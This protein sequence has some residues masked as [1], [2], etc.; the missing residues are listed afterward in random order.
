MTPKSLGGALY[1]MTSIDEHCRKIF[2]YTLKH[3]A[4]ALHLQGISCAKVE[5]ETNRKLKCVRLDNG[6]NY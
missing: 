1:I 2:L 3:V 5:R 6:G 4:G